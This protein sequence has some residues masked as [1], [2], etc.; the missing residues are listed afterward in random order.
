M[1][2][3]GLEPDPSRSKS[4]HLEGEERGLVRLSVHRCGELFRFHL[5]RLDF[6]LSLVLSVP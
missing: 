3:D 1:R 5:T 4:R 6:T 2:C